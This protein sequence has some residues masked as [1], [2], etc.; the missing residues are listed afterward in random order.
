MKMVFSNHG[1]DLFWLKQ[2]KKEK[3]K[4]NNSFG[5]DSCKTK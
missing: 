1:A 3:K 4:K 5:S 2:E